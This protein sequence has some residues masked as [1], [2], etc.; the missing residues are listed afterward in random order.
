MSYR[1]F[2]KRH[3]ERAK[4]RKLTTVRRVQRCPC[5]HAVCGNYFVTPEAAVQGVS[6]S[7]DQ[8]Y[9]VAQVLDFFDECERDLDEFALRLARNAFNQITRSYS[10]TL[11]RPAQLTSAIQISIIDSFT[12]RNRT[13]IV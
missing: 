12:S 7:R 8:A 6:Y 5:G 11:D 3:E 13:G 9:L 1:D 10:K 2:M 4:E